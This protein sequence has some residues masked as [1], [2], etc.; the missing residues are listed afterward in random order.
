MSD[1]E[2]LNSENFEEKVL[3]ASKPV[4]VDFWAS[5]CPPCRALGPTLE[6]VAKEME[7]QLEIMKVTSKLSQTSPDSMMSSISPP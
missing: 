5:W 1:L 2:S 6:E 3:R 4:L 7:G